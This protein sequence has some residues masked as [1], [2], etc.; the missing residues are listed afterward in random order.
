MF[1]NIYLSLSNGGH[2]FAYVWCLKNEYSN[3]LN[4]KLKFRNFSYEILKKLIKYLVNKIS[5]FKLHNGRP[6]MHVAGHE[7]L[8]LTHYFFVIIFP[9]KF[10]IKMSILL[11]ACASSIMC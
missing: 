3:F 5:K 11:R 1:F 2:K 7:T 6:C 10:Q 4:V 9:T 8:K